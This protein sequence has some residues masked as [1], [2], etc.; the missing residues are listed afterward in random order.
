MRYFI[1]QILVG[2]RYLWAEAPGV[3]LAG[4]VGALGASLLLGYVT[5]DAVVREHSYRRHA[6]FQ[7]EVLEAYKRTRGHINPAFCCHWRK[8]LQ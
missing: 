6:I 5:L 3:L 4:A 2:L 8:E 1:Q 7:Q